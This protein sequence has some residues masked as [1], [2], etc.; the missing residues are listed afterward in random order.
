MGEKR[1]IR[2]RGNSFSFRRGGSC[3]RK[4]AYLHGW[5]TGG[6]WVKLIRVDVFK[7]V[8]GLS[9][10]AGIKVPLAVFWVSDI[11]RKR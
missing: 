1:F 6:G 9:H 7:A 2:K 4:T 8:S 10:G 11:V 5:G 3:L